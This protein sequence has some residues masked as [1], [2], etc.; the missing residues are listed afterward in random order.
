[1]W[2]Q[3][4]AAIGS[5]CKSGKTMSGLYVLCLE[6]WQMLSRARWALFSTSGQIIGAL[7][8][9]LILAVYWLQNTVTS[10]RVVLWGKWQQNSEHYTLDTHQYP[11]SCLKPHI[12]AP[13][14]SC[15]QHLHPISPM[16]HS[17]SSC[18]LVVP[19]LL[20]NP[21]SCPLLKWCKVSPA[22]RDFWSLKVSYKLV[23][24]ALLLH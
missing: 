22:Y 8:T 17:Y 3:T 14:K 7:Q 24:K 21:S 12:S 4:H 19:L 2:V 20:S 15:L 9:C 5:P 23:Y 1:M 16:W 11:F 13:S 18:Y 6:E 10:H